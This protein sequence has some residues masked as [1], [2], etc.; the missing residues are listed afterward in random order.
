MRRLALTSV[1]LCALAFPAMAQDAEVGREYEVTIATEQNNA[2]TGQFGQARIGAVVFNI[3]DAKMNERYTVRVTDIRVNQYSGD[4][5]A[6]C[7]FQLIGGER[8]GM[9][10]AAP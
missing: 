1:A 3:P 5:Q 4:R 10:N 8:R 6:S 2:Y 9:C 7:E